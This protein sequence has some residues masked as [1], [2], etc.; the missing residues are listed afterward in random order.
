VVV[1][2]GLL[3][4]VVAFSSAD[5][6]AALGQEAIKKA[7]EKTYNVKVLRIQD[8]EQDGRQVYRVT[9]MNRGG[10]YNAAFQ[11]N[12]IVMDAETGKR[13]PQFRHLQSGYR[14]PAAHDRPVNRQA[15]DV[16]RR[17]WTWR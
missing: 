4:A 17:G 7:I 11:V 3:M 8:G 12:T 1:S 9:F 15:T 10:N 2:L 6:R 5:A 14:L 16:L 13:V